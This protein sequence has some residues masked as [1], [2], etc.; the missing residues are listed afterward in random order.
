MADTENDELTDPTDDEIE[1]ALAVIG[2]DPEAAPPPDASDDGYGSVLDEDEAQA[3]PEEGAQPRGPDGKFVKKDEPPPDEATKPENAT[4]EAPADAGASPSQEAAPA[5]PFAGW[6]PF[7]F[8]ADGVEASIAGIVANDT[9]VVIPRAVWDSEFRPKH[10]ANREAWQGERQQWQQRIQQA[11]GYAQQVEAQRTEREL[12]AEAILREHAAL[13]EDPNRLQAFLADFER[14]API[15]QARIEA[16][17]YK[18]Q[19]DQRAQAEKAARD[20]EDYEAMYQRSADA[21]ERDVRAMLADTKYA[22]LTS[23]DDEITDLLAEI[24]NP[25]LVLIPNR[26]VPELGYRRGEPIANRERITELLDRKAAFLMKRQAAW[27][28][29]TQAVTRNAAAVAPPATSPRTAKPSTPT[30]PP[31]A[32][33]VRAAKAPAP[34]ARAYR[35]TDEDKEAWSNDYAGLLD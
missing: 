31:A 33:P 5:D 6:S 12:Q 7:T 29:A 27:Q 14:Q 11:E 2:D 13:M 26:D 15:M 35:T 1:G 25:Q 34:P 17:T 28:Q 22:G 8:K 9:H 18:A 21:F 16:Q 19:L 4:P 23:N 24:W 32:P 30:K 10:L 20:R 3:P